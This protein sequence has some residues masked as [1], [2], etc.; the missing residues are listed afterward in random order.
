M[1]MCYGEK[2]NFRCKFAIYIHAEFAR[3][4]SILESPR[5]HFQGLKQ[6]RIQ[7]LRVGVHDIL[8][9]KVKK[10]SL[11]LEYKKH[12]DRFPPFLPFI[13]IFSF[14]SPFFPVVGRWKGISTKI[15]REGGTMLP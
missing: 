5:L 8:A 11:F 1:C 9:L 7:K 10:N 14:F 13:P 4:I 15:T 2:V 12:F 3:E 6:G